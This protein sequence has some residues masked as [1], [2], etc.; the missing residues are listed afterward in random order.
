MDDLGPTI[1]DPGKRGRQR[2]K[3]AQLLGI[4]PGAPTVTLDGE[5]VAI[6]RLPVN[7]VH[8]PSD[9]VSRRHAVIDRDGS[10][11][12]LQDLGSANG[13]ALNGKA[14]SAGERVQLQNQ[15]VV[16]IADDRFLFVDW[17]VQLP[18]APLADF[19]LDSAAVTDEVD[20]LLKEF[21]LKPQGGADEETV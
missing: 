6:G 5:R 10:R 14:M 2:P 18:D 20:R 4:S 3:T 8:L 13:T 16:R 7:D 1:R 15:D 19:Q 21:Q 17:R 12:L 9:R 11:W